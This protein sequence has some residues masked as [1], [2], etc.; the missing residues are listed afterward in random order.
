MGILN[1][2]DTSRIELEEDGFTPENQDEDDT[3]DEEEDSPDM[4]LDE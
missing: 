2:V 4:D 1:E 3:T